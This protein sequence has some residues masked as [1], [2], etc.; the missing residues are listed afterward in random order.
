[1]CLGDGAPSRRTAALS[2]SSKDTQIKSSVESSSY[3]YGQDTMVSIYFGLST[4]SVMDPEN[5]YFKNF[6][7][8]QKLSHVG[9]TAVSA[10]HAVL[11][12]CWNISTNERQRQ[13][14]EESRRRKS[15]SN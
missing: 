8:P 5:A 7:V 14:K 6:L 13:P 10:G 2:N 9:K 4:Q 1:M 3:G 12:A 11:G 15:K